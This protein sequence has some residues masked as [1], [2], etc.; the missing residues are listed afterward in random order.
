MYGCLGMCRSVGRFVSKCFAMCYNL[1]AG[2]YRC[3]YFKA[4]TKK[5]LHAYALLEYE[6]ICKYKQI[7][8]HL[9]LIAYVYAKIT[10]SKEMSFNKIDGA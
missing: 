9:Y 6:C 4:H 7:H 5:A 10:L 8:A 3:L 1:Y 2:K